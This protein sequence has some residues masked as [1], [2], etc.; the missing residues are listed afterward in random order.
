[1]SFAVLDWRFTDKHC[2]SCAC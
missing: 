2:S 1:L